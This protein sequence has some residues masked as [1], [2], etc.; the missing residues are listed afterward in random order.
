[1]LHRLSEIERLATDIFLAKHFCT[2]SVQ[3]YEPNERA[4]DVLL[5]ME[6]SDI[7]YAPVAGSN[8]QQFL[9]RDTLRTA[10]PNQLVGDLAQP[11]ANER[12]IKGDTSLRLALKDLASMNWLLVHE[13]DKLIG[14]LTLDD[15]A[16]PVVSTYLLARLLGLEHGLRR[17]VGTY[18]NEMLPDEPGEKGKG[19][20]WTIETTGN[21]VRRLNGLLHDLGYASGNKF[22]DDFKR[23]TKLR[24]HLAHARTLLH[25]AKTPQEA[26]RIVSDL[27]LLTTRIYELV[28]D[29]DAVWDSYEATQIVDA[30]DHSVVWA[31]RGAIPLPMETPIYVISAHNPFE[32]VLSQ[33]ENDKRHNLLK[34]HL[35]GHPSEREIQFKEV[36]GKSMTGPWNETSIAVSGITQPE[37]RRIGERFGQRAIFELTESEVRIVPI[38]GEQRRPLPRNLTGGA[39]LTDN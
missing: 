39:S 18:S 11:T 14:I 24:N 32:K 9:S 25:V 29:R 15:L 12:W 22:E 19:D 23:Y 37:A 34:L 7:D 35:D 3:Q 26:A 13:N 4:K 6:L 17:L 31:G 36:I 38:D 30:S 28:L 21:R 8:G 16:S 33:A 27:E 2:R 10:A 5:W 1:M 20:G